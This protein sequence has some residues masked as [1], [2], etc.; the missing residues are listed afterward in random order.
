MSAAPRVSSK[1]KARNPGMVC[2]C[3]HATPDIHRRRDAAVAEKKRK[4][5]GGKQDECPS[6]GQDAF[7]TLILGLKQFEIAKWCGHGSGW[8]RTHG[9]SMSANLPGL[10]LCRALR[11]ARTARVFQ[12]SGK[13]LIG[14]VKERGPLLAARGQFIV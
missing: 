14:Q 12:S 9:G 4:E 11:R 5:G 2:Y 10:F 1:D 13:V 3:L 7:W 6:E 8:S